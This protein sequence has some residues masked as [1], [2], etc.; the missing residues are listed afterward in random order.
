MRGNV[1][2]GHGLGSLQKNCDGTKDPIIELHWIL[3]L[4]ALLVDR[5]DGKDIVAIEERSKIRSGE[6]ESERYGEE[7]DA[8]NEEIC[9]C[10]ESDIKMMRGGSP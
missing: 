3:W 10:D 6:M 4:V 8:S 2:V 1:H 9:L 7:A 5:H